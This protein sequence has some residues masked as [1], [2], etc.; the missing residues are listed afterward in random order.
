MTTATLTMPTRPVPEIP[1]DLAIK[2][3]VL[4]A[5]RAMRRVF[6][7]A[8]RIASTR[9]TVLIS[10]ETGT[11][12][13]VVARY[14]HKLS[15]RR[16]HSMVVFHCAACPESLMESEIF[17]HE[18]GAYTGATHPRAGVFERA[19]GGTLLLDEVGD[20]APASQGKLLR[21]LQER[22]LSRLGSTATLDCDA[23][24]VATT[25]RDLL[26]LAQRGLF[27][28]DLFYRL[29]VFPLHVPPLRLRREDIP[30][31][32]KYFTE[33]FARQHRSRQSGVTDEAM[34]ILVSYHWPGN[35]R[36][37][38]SAIERAL[39]LAEGD[40]ITPEHLPPDVRAGFIR[41]VCGES[42]TSLS[43]GQRLMVSRAL[44][45]T[46]WD[47]SRAAAHLGVSPHVL[48]QMVARMGLKRD[49]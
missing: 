40:P 34:A 3:T 45:E 36:E 31:L 24:I 17:G 37:L 35:V 43:Y 22:R 19:H 1:I 18:R 21:V 42:L 8:A 33:S 9:S 14:I 39:L 32:A 6:E 2:T 38:Q 20:L 7:L 29:N 44:F 26:K 47:F 23:R 11:G 15:P 4:G 27:R 10:G 5:S 28:E 13:E 25:H 46:H 48:R 41:P 30:Y 49:G 16:D 12:K